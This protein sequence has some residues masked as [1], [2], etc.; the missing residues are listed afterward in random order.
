MQYDALMTCCGCKSSV[1]SRTTTDD[2]IL[3]QVLWSK[4]CFLWKTH[5]LDGLVAHN[6]TGTTMSKVCAIWHN[7]IMIWSIVIILRQ[8]ECKHSTADLEIQGKRQG[9]S[10]S[11][12]LSVLKMSFVAGG[13]R[14]KTFSTRSKKTR[15]LRERGQNI[16]Q[17]KH[18]CRALLLVVC[19]HF[20]QKQSN[21]TTSNKHG[22]SQRIIFER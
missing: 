21:T 8:Q 15:L 7:S 3:L 22:Y 1:S 18:C 6:L 19:D 10:A 13:T 16:A 9:G 14:P 2:V 20:L 17:G 12:D 4:L 5:A 11:K